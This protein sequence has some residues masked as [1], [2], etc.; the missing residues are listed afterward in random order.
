M[1]I[2]PMHNLSLELDIT[3]RFLAMFKVPLWA[4]KLPSQVGKP[5]GG[6]LSADE[7]KLATTYT[8][9]IVM[10]GA[11]FMHTLKKQK[12]DV[13]PKPPKD[14]HLCL[15][16]NEP[17]NLLHLSTVLKI[18]CRSSLYGA[19]AMKPN[20]HWAIHLEDFNSNNWMSGGQLE[21]SMMQEFS[22][23]MHMEALV[24]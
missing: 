3:H 13:E 18:F 10:A 5:A 23:R 4:G 21:I 8:W 6:S 16:P 24:C 17:I 14:P 1:I 22:H 19:K 11:S 15:H 7:Y 12:V 2:N 20:F 9:P